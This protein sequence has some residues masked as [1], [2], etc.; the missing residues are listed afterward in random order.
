MAITFSFATPLQA[1][2]TPLA[3]LV[4]RGFDNDLASHR[5]HRLALSDVI[6]NAASVDS[7]AAEHQS[8]ASSATARAN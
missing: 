7:H 2:E 6:A 5:Y 3:Q 1:L 4:H 8:A